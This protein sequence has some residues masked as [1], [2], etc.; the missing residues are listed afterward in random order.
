MLEFLKGKVNDRKLRLFA[1]ACC[2]QVWH[3]LDEH[4]RTAV[5]VVEQNVDGPSK[6]ETWAVAEMGLCLGDQRGSRTMMMALPP[7]WLVVVTLL[8]GQAENVTRLVARIAWSVHAKANDTHAALR[9]PPG[10]EVRA[11]RAAWATAQKAKTQEKAFQCG[12]LRE[13]SGN[14]FRPLSND[15]SRRTPKVARL[16]QSIY[17]DRAFD[18][19]PVLADALEEAGC[20]DQPILDHCR[21]PGPHA[22]GC[23]VVDLLIA[24]S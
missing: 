5:E 17:D 11:A 2:H 7:W 18:R 10:D 8:T 16:A 14:P 13:I 15:P 4:S 12:L 1:V 21:G 23:W 22:R 6:L 9:A 19:M 3:L 24:K 20:T